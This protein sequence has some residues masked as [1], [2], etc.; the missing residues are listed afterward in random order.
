MDTPGGTLGLN[1]GLI[2][3][4]DIDMINFQRTI[5]AS[6]AVFTGYRF[7]TYWNGGPPQNLIV[8]VD[9]YAHHD[10]SLGTPWPFTAGVPVIL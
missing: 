5:N 6:S 3:D 4:T 7:I 1:Q 2:W 10:E 8:W 9:D